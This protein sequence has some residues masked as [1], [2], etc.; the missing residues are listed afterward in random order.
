MLAGVVG[1]LGIFGVQFPSLPLHFNTIGTIN[2][3]TL[4]LVSAAILGL[5]LYSVDGTNGQAIIAKGVWGVFTKIFVYSTAVLAVFF[6]LVVDYWLFWL[7][8]VIGLVMLFSLALFSS[9]EFTFPK[10]L[11]LPL[12]FLII[13]VVFIFVPSPLYMLK[14]PIVVTPSYTISWFISVKTVS[15]SWVQTVFGSGP[16]TFHLDFA[17]YKPAVINQ[18]AFWSTDFDRAK[19]QAMTTLATTGILGVAVWLLLVVWTLLRGVGTLL[20]ER[21]KE[22]WVMSY[23]FFLGWFTVMVVHLLYV[24]N[25]T[26]NFLFWAMLGLLASQW[27]K[28]IVNKSFVAAPRAGFVAIFLF[29]TMG[30]GLLI[31]LF[32]LGQRY[33]AEVNFTQAVVLS[34]QSREQEPV[35][36]KLI[37]A[38]NLVPYSDVYARNLSMAL[39]VSAKGILDKAG[40]DPAKEALAEAQKFITAGETAGQNATQ[41]SSHNSANWAARGYFYRELMNYVP[42]SQSQAATSYNQAISYSPSNPVYYTDL[43]RVHMAVAARARVLKP[44]KDAK[45]AQQAAEAEVTQLAEAEKNFRQA[46]TLKNDY[47]LPHYYL[48]AVLERQGRVQESVDQMAALAKQNPMDLGLGFELSQLY[49]RRGDLDKAQVELERL[50]ALSPDYSDV[51]WYLAS[52]YELKNNRLKAIEILEQVVKLNPDNTDVKK[53]LDDVKAGKKTVEMPQPISETTPTTIAQ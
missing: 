30:A 34:K 2:N 52:V 21:N 50:L 43:G 5:A 11:F 16:G 42:N 4:F 7:I 29:V 37:R 53:R 8:A 3:L 9:K 31:S 49:L 36:N 32:L 48:A 18:T 20:R 19:S 6:L 22:E 24:S 25:F 28:K 39:L 27:S 41:A 33:V 23:V 51:L 12:A 35:T 46:I 1:V 44:A 26:L 14:A 10:R 47:S 38:A 17:Q 40:A 45:L 15:A 13:S